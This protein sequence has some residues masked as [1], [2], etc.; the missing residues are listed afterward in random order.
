MDVQDKDTEDDSLEVV[1]VVHAVGAIA[2]ME[3]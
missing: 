1:V 3:K 2:G